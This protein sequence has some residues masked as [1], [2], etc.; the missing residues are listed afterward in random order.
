MNQTIILISFF[1]LLDTVTY[2]PLYHKKNLA[3]NYNF[4][5]L[6]AQIKSRYNLRNKQQFL[7]THSS[8]IISP[9]C[10]KTQHDHYKSTY[11]THTIK[12]T[13]FHVCFHINYPKKLPNNKKKSS[14]LSQQILLRKRS[15][16]TIHIHYYASRYIKT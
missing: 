15:S 3:F 14:P 5:L 4:T 8:T 7:K 1:V 6:N 9:K 11:T 16:I 12:I 2:R 13:T 10:L